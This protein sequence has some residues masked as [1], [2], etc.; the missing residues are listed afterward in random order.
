MLTPR[1]TECTDCGDMLSLIDD[2]D[3]KMAK[4]AGNLYNNITLMLN[5]ST[6]VDVMIDLLTYKR[7][8]QYKYVNSLYASRFSIGQIANRVNLLKF[9]A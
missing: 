1:L 3:C 6:P 2:I 9:K 7:I 8:L 5:K 4:L